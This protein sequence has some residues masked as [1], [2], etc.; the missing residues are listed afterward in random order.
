LDR[1]A[2]IGF[3]WVWFLSV[4][5][6]GPA[7]QRVSRTNQEWRREFHETLA[8]L[9]E[10]DILGLGFAIT[11]YTVHDY[12]GGDT[13]LAR[14][15]A[16]LHKRDLKLML[17]FVPNHTALDHPWVEK[18]PEYYIRGAEQDLARAPMNYIWAKRKRGNLLLAG[19]TWVCWLCL[20]SSSAVGGSR[21]KPSGRTLFAACAGNHRIFVLWRRWVTTQQLSPNKAHGPGSRGNFA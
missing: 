8:D 21:P 3:D 1:I 6:T 2:A 7:G 9:C 4:W 15:R 18:H 17:D 12:L 16:R 14:L 19:A 5:Q 10:E 20:K 13:A 11:G